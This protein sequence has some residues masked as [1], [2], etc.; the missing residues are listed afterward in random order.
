MN[1]TLTP[2]WQSLLQHQTRLE[3]K[4]L[5][6]LFAEDPQRFKRFSAELDG[7]LI[8]YSKQRIDQPALDGLLALAR[9][10]NVEAWRDRMFF[11]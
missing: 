8:D 11:R 5:R 2:E 7:L 1:I 3:Q 6:D 10:S 4:H 9:L